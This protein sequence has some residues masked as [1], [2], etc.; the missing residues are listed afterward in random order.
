[1]AGD[2]DGQRRP[3]MAASR[4]ADATTVVAAERHRADGHGMPAEA[5]K[6]P[7]WVFVTFAVLLAGLLVP[8]IGISAG[9]SIP[10][11]A[12]STTTTMIAWL[13]VGV[14]TATSNCLLIGAAL[15]ATRSVTADTVQTRL[16][17]RARLLTRPARLLTLVATLGA[18]VVAAATMRVPPGG[19]WLAIVFS[20]AFWP[21]LTW[22]AG[23]QLQHAIAL[24]YNG[25]ATRQQDAG[26]T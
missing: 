17:H 6:R 14:L 15:L 20:G 4:D 22:Y 16:L 5:G 3:P 10:G 7:A 21:A 25:I 23:N 13:V 26:Q 1:V 12:T 9:V 8:T 24:T 18:L 11:H 19:L 2:H